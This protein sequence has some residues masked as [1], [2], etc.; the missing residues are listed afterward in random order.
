MSQTAYTPQPP[1]VQYGPPRRSFAGPIILIALGLL[2]LLGNLRVV[3]WYRIGYYFSR[4]W[5]VL[6]ILWGVIKLIEYFVGPGEGRR[7][8]RVGAGSVVLIVFIIIAGLTAHGIY[9]VNWNAVGD[10]FDLNHGGGWWAGDW[11]TQ[12]Y[13]FTQELQQEFPAGASLR[14]SSDRGAVT[15]NTWDQKQIKVTVAKHVRAADEQEANKTDQAT[16]PQITVTGNEVLLNAN[17]SSG[18]SRWVA[19]DLEIFVPRDASVNVATRN[20]DINIRARN[21]DVQISDSHGTVTLDDIKGNV[22]INL[23][24]GTARVAKVSGDVTIDGEVEEANVSD[25]GGG[26][27]LNGGVTDTLSLARV[28]KGVRYQS[29]RT[30]MQF[31]KLD[32]EL[33]L[34]GGDLNVKQVTG[35]VQ[36]STRSKEI[37]LD[38]VTGEVR[39]ENSNGIIEVQS[40]LPLGAMQLSNRRGSVRVVLPAKA[41]FQ[42]DARTRRGD[43]NSDFPGLSVQSGHQQ[44]TASGTIGSG[45]PRLDIET[46]GGDVE[47]R[48][49]G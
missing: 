12:T 37:H 1:Q 44:S 27:T 31:A 10:D 13:N 7:Y 48:K 45:G 49:A 46:D 24:R 4:Y 18:G 20:G 8:N 26:V 9:G 16:H 19:S 6:I 32:G 2:F 21:G 22:S 41:A 25:I 28:G 3:P 33:T 47:I 5:P 38:D 43:I 34:S 17:T 14:V 42:I 11:G 35:P 30:T 29:N 39:V 40:K 36:L 23:R 15:V